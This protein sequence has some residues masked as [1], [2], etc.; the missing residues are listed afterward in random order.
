MNTTPQ[1]YPTCSPEMLANITDMIAKPNI[2]S[3]PVL[4][5]L[6]AYYLKREQFEVI[7]IIDEEIKQRK[8]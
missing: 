6:R 5:Q 1:T 7:P 8:G 3:V 4:E 2:Y